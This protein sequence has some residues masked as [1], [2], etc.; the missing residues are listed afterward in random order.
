MGF[1]LFSLCVCV[2]IYILPLAYSCAD[3]SAFNP[4]LS[5][6]GELNCTSILSQGGL[7]SPWDC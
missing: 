2:Y 5:S 6:Y 3:E 7:N 1:N 4:L